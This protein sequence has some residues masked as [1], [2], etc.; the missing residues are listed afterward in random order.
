MQDGHQQSGLFS[1]LSI[2][3]IQII[4]IMSAL[5]RKVC[6]NC[7]CQREEHDIRDDSKE[8]TGAHVGKLLFSPSVD[9]FMKNS[10]GAI[11]M[12]MAHE[13]SLSPT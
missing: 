3:A 10:T 2:Y 6:K 13:I 5:L 8:D 12:T 4:T 7:L 1:P 9:T 11:R